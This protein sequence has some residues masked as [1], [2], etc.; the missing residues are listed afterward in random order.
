MSENNGQNKPASPSPGIPPVKLNIRNILI[1]AAIV[2]AAILIFVFGI[3][4]W[5]IEFKLTGDESV[6]SEC[7]EPYRDQGA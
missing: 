6:T 1:I 5:S 3:N 2:I 7:G 4:K